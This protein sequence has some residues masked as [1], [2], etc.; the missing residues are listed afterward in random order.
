MWTLSP[1]S[2]AEY[3]KLHKEVSDL[4]AANAKLMDTT[5]KY[6]ELVDFLLAEHQNKR[7]PPHIFQKLYEIT[8]SKK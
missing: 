5:D 8:R 4:L 7:L 1:I 3:E 6:I 2:V